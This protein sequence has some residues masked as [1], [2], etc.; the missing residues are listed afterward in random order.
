VDAGKRRK[1]PMEE[2][3]CATVNGSKIIG[4]PE[5]IGSLEPGK[6]ADLIVLDK[7]PLDDIHNTNTV[8]WVMKNGELYEGDTLDQLWPEQKKLGP[9]WFWKFDQPK[10]GEPLHY[11]ATTKP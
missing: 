10:A 5:D 2:L 8:H 6:L 7:N 1:T 11:G 3:R 4:R 9:L